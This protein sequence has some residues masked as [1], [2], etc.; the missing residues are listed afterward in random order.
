MSRVRCLTALVFAIGFSPLVHAQA[1]GTDNSVELSL[2]GRG[3]VSAV[4]DV[5]VEPPYAYALERGILR[6]LD[7]RN[8]TAIHEVASLEIDRPRVRMALRHPYLYLTGFGNPLG[9]IDI[10]NPMNPRWVAEF[11]EFFGQ[12]DVF[13]IEGSTA[14]F[15]RGG[16]LRG[17]GQPLL[18]DV[19]DL[20]E[21]PARPRRIG[22]VELGVRVLGEYGGIACV[23]GRA[24]VLVRNTMENVDQSQLIIVDVRVPTEPRI[25]R[26]MF[27]PE[28][29]RYRDI[30]V[31]GDLIYLLRWGRW[32]RRDDGLAIYRLRQNEDPELLGESLTDAIS[33]SIDLVVHG[34]VV[35]ATF[36]IGAMLAAYDVS[37]PSNP[38]LCYTHADPGASG[39][40]LT[41]VNDRLYVTGDNEPMPI[42]D[43]SDS[44]M[45]RLLGRWNFEGGSVSDVVLDGDVAILSNYNGDLYLYDVENPRVPRRLARYHGYPP[46]TSRE[47][48]QWNMVTAAKGSRVFVAYE[49]IAAQVVDIRDPSRPVQLGT[50]L[51]KGLVRAVALTENHAFLGYQSGADGK[52]PRI[53][54]ASSLSEVGGIEVIDLADPKS[55]RSVA[56]LPLEHAVTDLVLRQGRLMVSHPNGAFTVVDVHD[57]LRPHVLGHLDS[58]R[59]NADRSSAASQLAISDDASRGYL[60]HG[61]TLRL[62]DLRNPASPGISSELLVDGPVV[63]IE[64]ST[65]HDDRVILLQRDGWRLA[66]VDATN[67]KSPAIIS[68]HRVR[69]R[70]VAVRGPYL[71]LGAYEDGLLVY[72]LSS[73]ER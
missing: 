49:T 34:D 62:L 1:L 73:S 59:S 52:T 18:L 55:P 38:N 63:D 3:R 64:L 69:A 8:P 56:D 68:N 53:I 54:D 43:V 65:I 72:R 48:W 23:R 32:Q 58:N 36:K 33:S 37:D 15:V 2:V 39:L 47:E 27:F 42:F 4:Y 66:I 67:P 28:G 7:V 60:A 41:L 9:V 20:G 71:Y 21:D 22:S 11:P 31:E 30:E 70:R 46:I 35:Y 57:P 19:L 25:E 5:E 26:R 16:R 40:G 24:F 50:I 51:P 12:G 6:V 17:D 29:E 10:S 61:K 44:R 14:Y 45:P 13:E